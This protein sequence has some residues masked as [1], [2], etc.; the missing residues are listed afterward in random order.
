MPRAADSELRD[1]ASPGSPVVDRRFAL[2][3]ALALVAVCVVLWLIGWSLRGWISAWP[4]FKDDAYY[5]LV[6]ARN[7]SAGH[8]FTM[9]QMSPTNGFHPLWMWTLLPV[10]RIVG[11]DPDVL[12]LVVQAL[13][14]ALFACAGGLLCGIVRARAGVAPALLVALLLLFPRIENA[15]L[16]GLESALVLL[17]LVGLIAEMLR[18]GALSETEPRPVDD[19]RTGALVGLLMLARLDSVFIGVTLAF[20][21]L[22]RGLAGGAGPFSSRL[23]RTVRKELSVFWPAVVLLVPYLLSNYLAFGHLTPI[24]GTLKTSFP[25]AGFSPTHLNLEHVV[26]FAF[27][28][29]GAGLEIG[30]GHGRDPL[31]RL[32]ALLTVGIALHALYTVVYMRWAVLSW[33]FIA[34]VPV[35]ALGAALLAREAVARLPRALVFAALGALA[36]L[37]VGALAKSLSNLE[38]TFTVASQEAGEWV[39][40]NLPPDAVLSMKDSGIFTYF[41]QRRVMNL[42]GVANSFE[43]ANALCAGRLEEFLRSHGV[44]YVAQHSVPESVRAGAYETHTQIYP[45]HLRGGRDGALV[46]RREFEV[47]RGTPYTTNAET[48]DQLVIWRLAPPPT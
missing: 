30:R 25:V 36:L 41:A 13:C 37:Q 9:D 42:D 38:K 2:A 48:P 11:S 23:A 21:V 43:Y 32:L 31:V 45:C 26:L 6:I 7:A 1:A 44:E 33:H 18:S 22:V 34:F 20:Y 14:V 24:S 28:L 46:L 15:A 19:A 47:Y 4:R 29:G 39:A 5:Y 8:G 35:G 12:L 16:S 3:V 27:A 17:V 10:V 40:E